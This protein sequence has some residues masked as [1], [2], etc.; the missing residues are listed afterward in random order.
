VNYTID[1]H[2]YYRTQTTLTCWVKIY[3]NANIS[4][5][6]YQRTNTQT[7]K[8]NTEILYTNTAM[9]KIQFTLE[10]LLQSKWR[11]IDQSE[12]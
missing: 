3:Q 2:D 12:I 9:K 7:V 4:I 1:R 6:G 10:N 5:T 11:I 8:I